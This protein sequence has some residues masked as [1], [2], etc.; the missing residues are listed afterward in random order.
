MFHSAAFKFSIQPKKMGEALHQQ[1]TSITLFHKMTSEHFKI[2]ENYRREHYRVPV[3]QDLPFHLQIK[4]YVKGEDGLYWACN[5]MDISAGGLAAILPFENK[6]HLFKAYTM[7]DAVLE[8]GGNR[9]KCSLYTV[10][11]CRIDLS[12]KARKFMQKLGKIKTPN[13]EISGVKI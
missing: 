3:T 1:L 8:F 7:H 9:Y 12:I 11:S 10:R 4:L 13:T 5:V 6:G 2:S